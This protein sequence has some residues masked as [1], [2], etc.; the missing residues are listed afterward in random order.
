LPAKGLS[1][2]HEGQKKAM[3]STQW[4]IWSAFV[5]QAPHPIVRWNGSI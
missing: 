4:P 2:I 1:V 5:Q 3:G